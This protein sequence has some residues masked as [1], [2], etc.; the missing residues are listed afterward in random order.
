MRA[1]PAATLI[2]LVALAAHAQEPVRKPAKEPAEIRIAIV[3]CERVEEAV[4]ERLLRTDPDYRVLHA[5]R[6]ADPLEERQDELERLMTAT[7]DKATAEAIA[8]H[9]EKAGYPFVLD[10]DS[11]LKGAVVYR[12]RDKVLF[13]DIT[14][15]VL[16]AA[17]VSPRDRD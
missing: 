15:D 1:L 6:K 8:R 9:A 10:A 4:E 17:G 11:Y 12:Q 5:E 2:V 16:D 7:R 3:N 13:I 14:Q